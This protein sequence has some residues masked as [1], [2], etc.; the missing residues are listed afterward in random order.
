MRIRIMLQYAA[1]TISISV[2][3]NDSNDYNAVKAVVNHPNSYH[4]WVV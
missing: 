1:I 3:K 2:I 4:T